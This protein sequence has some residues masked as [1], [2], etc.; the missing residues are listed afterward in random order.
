MS[1]KR[2]KLNRKA[3]KEVLFQ[4]VIT[5]LK[6]GDVNVQGFPNNVKDATK[7]AGD[8]NAAMFNYFVQQASKGLVD[9]RG[10]VIQS[11][12]IAPGPDALKVVKGLSG[13]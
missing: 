4:T 12:I 7:L 2:A 9:K 10:V 8:F 3:K 13:K 6:N 5:V 1:E 11:K